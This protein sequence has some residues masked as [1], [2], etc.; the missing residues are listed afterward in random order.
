MAVLLMVLCPMCLGLLP[1]LTLPEALAPPVMALPAWLP[2]G[3]AFRC[4]LTRWEQPVLAV[5]IPLRVSQCAPVRPLGQL[6]SRT[7]THQGQRH[8][9]SH[10]RHQFPG[11]LPVG[12]LTR[13][14]AWAAELGRI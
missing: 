9:L 10:L 7:A 4:A 14:P 3:T 12:A 8:L 6:V 1:V 11:Q 5:R 13:A 2:R